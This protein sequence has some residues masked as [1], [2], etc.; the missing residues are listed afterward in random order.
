[1]SAMDRDDAELKKMTHLNALI[2]KTLSA[3]QVQR[4][5]F[6]VFKSD[7]DNCVLYTLLPL[8]Q[9]VQQPAEY[10]DGTPVVEDGVPVMEDVLDDDGHSVKEEVGIELTAQ[11]YKAH[12][13]DAA[14][15]KKRGNHTLLSRISDPMSRKIYGV[16]LISLKRTGG[17]AS[18]N[19]D[20]ADEEV[21]IDAEDDDDDVDEERMR[22]DMSLMRLLGQNDLKPMLH[23]LEDPTGGDAL[24]GEIRANLDGVPS[25]LV[26]AFVHMSSGMLG[27]P[28]IDSVH[29][30]G[31]SIAKGEWTSM[32]VTPSAATMARAM[33]V[34]LG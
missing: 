13:P 5:L 3:E 27:M 12:G 7:N 2:S 30:Y 11:W 9:R 6:K 16:E 33:S 24:L 10:E 4:T 19:P 22:V 1:M 31:T 21:L 18:S 25:R 8:M 15:E 28:N 32:V 17:Q 23:I 26:E 20:G 14:A 34:I 29:I